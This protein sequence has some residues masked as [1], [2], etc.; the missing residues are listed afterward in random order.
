MLELAIWTKSRPLPLEA[1]WLSSPPKTAAFT[2]VGF[3]VAGKQAFWALAAAP[4]ATD[5]RIPWKRWIESARLKLAHAPQRFRN[6]KDLADFL[7][8]TG[9]TASVRSSLTSGVEEKWFVG[10]K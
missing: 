3:T 9:F 7:L 1:C 8:A 4:N 10:R 2:G 6:E 5:R